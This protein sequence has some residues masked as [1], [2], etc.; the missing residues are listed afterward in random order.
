MS[1]QVSKLSSFLLF[2]GFLCSP[3]LQK[4]CPLDSHSHSNV[5]NTQCNVPLYPSPSPHLRPSRPNLPPNLLYPLPPPFLPLHL[6]RSHIPSLP[7]HLP[8]VPYPNCLVPP[9]RSSAVGRSD[10]VVI[11]RVNMAEHGDLPGIFSSVAKVPGPVFGEA[12]SVVEGME[13]FEEGKLSGFG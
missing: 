10:M 2:P 4:Q 1:L 11:H 9:P 6:H 7:H 3:G 8:R 12:E 5:S 13:E